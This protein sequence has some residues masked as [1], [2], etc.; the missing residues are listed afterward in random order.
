M[1]MF[2]DLR[3]TLLGLHKAL[4]LFAVY[5]PELDHYSLFLD[6][7][8]STQ[9]D[10]SRRPNVQGSRSSL[11]IDYGHDL[12][13]QEQRKTTLFLDAFVFVKK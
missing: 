4:G 1:I 10:R 6:G 12:K 8:L 3:L 7:L 11:C 13:F 2:M 9:S 5:V